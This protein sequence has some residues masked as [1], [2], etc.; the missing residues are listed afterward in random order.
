MVTRICWLMG[1][2]MI[3]S[4]SAFAED[5]AQGTFIYVL[6]EG[7]SEAVRIGGVPGYPAIYSP[8]ISPN[9]EWV[10]VDGRQ[11]GQNAGASH[12]LLVSISDGSFKDL[13][14][15]MMP[16]WSADGEK[17]AYT[18]PG[19]GLC[20]C[21]LNGEDQ[22]LITQSGF[23]V[24]WSP[25]GLS[26][27]FARG[28]SLIIY[29]LLTKTERVLVGDAYRQIYWNLAWSHDSKYICFKGDSKLGGSEIVVVAVDGE[30]PPRPL[31]TGEHY[32][33]DFAWHP[34][35][36]Q[37]ALPHRA[38]QE[39]KFGQI[40]SINPQINPSE[41]DGAFTPLEPPIPMPIQ[42]KDRHNSG[43]SWSRDGKLF[44]FVSSRS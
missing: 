26:L 32:N 10:A 2:V 5:S 41:I 8:E 43:M 38:D 31:C 21:S 16:S 27:A 11:T 18:K 42:P 30:S 20:I 35:G 1:L 13:G 28:G 34:D 22:E 23:G 33:P 17:L 9:Q 19:A 7:Q 29:D 6:A 25:D 3:L 40:Y 24:Q 4:A 14:E 36:N 39:H 15:G 37:I 44:V 12:L